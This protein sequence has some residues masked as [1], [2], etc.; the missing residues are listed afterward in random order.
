[1]GVMGQNLALNAADNGFV[2]S[3]YN[4]PDEFQA[5]I[6]GALDRAKREGRKDGKGE[7]TIH[8][9]TELEPFVASLRV[10]R[11]ILL[12]IPAGKP[13]EMTIEAL[14]P[15][16]ARDDIIIDG[17]NEHFA[18]T[19]RREA[20]LAASHGL[21]FVGMG[22]SGGAEGA[23]HG[24][25]LM[26]GGSEHA[27]ASLAPIL[28][29]MAA[30]APTADGSPDPP[31]A[32]AP[33]VT[34][35]GPNGAGHYVKMVHNG[36][37]YADMQLIAECYDLLRNV[38]GMGNDE[39]RA[40]MDEWNG[41]PLES[42]LVEI[43]AKVLRKRDD[44]E[45]ETG[46]LVD[47]ILDRAGSKGTGKWTVQLA[48]DSGIAAPSVSAALEA[49]KGRWERGGRNLLFF[50]LFLFWAPYNNRARAF[51]WSFALPREARTRRSG[52]RGSSPQLLCVS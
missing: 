41:G 34:H 7:M 10:P 16:L 26:P 4:R 13:V 40:A 21:H 19:V 24:P 46:H 23:R 2:V 14:T 29:A 11:R 38:G 25:S 36:V 32:G 27:Y 22:I 17:G 44:R 45:G 12:S 52:R 50:L 20:S 28:E 9:F 30:K 6:L 48:A 42:F 31:G 39:V 15:L 33:C 49:G 37:E 51:V 47:K 1:M 8:A 43:T 3:A 35:V 5:R 18:E